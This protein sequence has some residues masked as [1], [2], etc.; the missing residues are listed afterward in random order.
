MNYTTLIT[1]IAVGATCAIAGIKL[2]RKIGQKESIMTLWGEQLDQANED[3]EAALE[4]LR[5][6]KLPMEDFTDMY[7]DIQDS[8]KREVAQIDEMYEEIINKL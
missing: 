5:G 7:N 3:R 2:G 6:R 4:A 1:A 8:Y